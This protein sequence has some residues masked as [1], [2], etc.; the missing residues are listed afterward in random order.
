MPSTK[1]DYA[2]PIYNAYTPF[3][4]GVV[5]I[6]D[7]DNGYT[8]TGALLYDGRA[9]LTSAHVIDKYPSQ[10]KILF[11][12]EYEQ[13]NYLYASSYSIIPLY[14]RNVEFSSHDLALVW[15]DEQAPSFASRY[16]IYRDNPLFE[17]FNFAG[18][19][20][21]ATGSVGLDESLQSSTTMRIQ[22]HN[23]FEAYYSDLD[24]QSY[25]NSELAAD[26]DSG[27]KEDDAFGN[28]FDIPNLGLGNYEGIPLPGDSGGPAWI[29]GKIAGVTKGVGKYDENMDKPYGVYGDVGVWMNIAF[30]TYQQWIDQSLRSRYENAPKS[31]SEVKTSIAEGGQNEISIIYFLLEFNGLR[32]NPDDWLSVDYATREQTALS[33]IDFIPV[34]GTLILYPDEYSAVIPVEIIGNDIPQPDREF[35]LDITNPIGGTFPNG[36]EMLSAKRTIIDDDGYTI[37]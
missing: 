7:T 20:A 29:D 3:Y 15:L 32:D 13:R 21:L 23:T 30:S 18:Y 4:S 8:G 24:D 25:P 9:L 11:E 35:Y 1:L 33:Y 36:L 34:S 17:D 27:Y 37:A 22:A 28:L 19:G 31:A 10:L 5:K 16:D 2:D 26:F 12:E 14:D 6:I